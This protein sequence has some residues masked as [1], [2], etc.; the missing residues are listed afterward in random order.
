MVFSFEPG[1]DKDKP[2]TAED[3]VELA[4]TLNDIEFK[5]MTDYSGWRIETTEYF[6]E[7]WM[8]DV[9]DEESMDDQTNHQEEDTETSTTQ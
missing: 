5:T 2:V 7:D 9:P 6:G 4:V 3:L 1:M 8:A